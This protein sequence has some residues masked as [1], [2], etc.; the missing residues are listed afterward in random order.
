M[1]RMDE[2]NG[3]SSPPLEIC[4]LGRFGIHVRARPV[5]ET[6][7]QGRKG[8]SLLKLVALQRQARIT[9]DR[10]MD[11]LWPHL[12]ESAAASQLYKALHHIRSVFAQESEE[13]D[14][15]IEIT[16]D[17]IR[18]RGAV[19]RR[20]LGSAGIG[21]PSGMPLPTRSTSRTVN[22]H[23]PSLTGPGGRGDDATQS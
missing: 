1:F 13:A 17:L 8:R 14:E 16:D 7:I 15:W 18:P 9:R 19:R 5:P 6:A 4:L 23:G 11:V 2:R 22:D 21:R 20:S 10:A 12:E 3:D